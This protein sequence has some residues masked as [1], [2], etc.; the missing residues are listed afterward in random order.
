MK[1]YM[2]LE[3]GFHELRR[4]EWI[5]RFRCPAISAF[6]GGRYLQNRYLLV[7]S[8]HLARALR[9]LPAHM[10]YSTTY[11]SAAPLPDSESHRA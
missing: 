8:G 7:A 4:V 3:G 10:C 6:W 9:Y 1:V 11:S 2:Q 5:S